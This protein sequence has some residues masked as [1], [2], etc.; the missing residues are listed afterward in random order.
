MVLQKGEN[1]RVI[2]R[3]K[4]KKVELSVVV[5]YD[6]FVYCTKLRYLIV[7]SGFTREKQLH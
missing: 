6:L 2:K 5:M 4:K 1:I 3:G 7:S